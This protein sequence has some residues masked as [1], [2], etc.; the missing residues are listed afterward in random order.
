MYLVWRIE[1]LSEKARCGAERVPVNF[2]DLLAM[3]E[4]DDDFAR[5][6]IGEESASVVSVI[7]EQSRWHGGRTPSS[8]QRGE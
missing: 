3:G 7:F 4:T 5:Q 2:D 6:N 8:A 1:Q